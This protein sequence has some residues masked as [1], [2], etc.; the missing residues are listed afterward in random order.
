LDAG[1]C[2]GQF[3]VIRIESK[4]RYALVGIRKY[5]DAYRRARARAMLREVR[6]G[7]TAANCSG[8]FDISERCA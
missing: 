7:T 2:V 1:D 3:V 4:C 5:K 6:A 8:G